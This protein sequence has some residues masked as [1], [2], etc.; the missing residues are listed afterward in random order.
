MATLGCG[1]AAR[2]SMAAIDI[3]LWDLTGKLTGESISALIGD[4]S[5]DRLQVYASHGLGDDLGN[6]EASARQ[7]MT[8]GFVAVNF[9]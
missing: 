4:R 7:L 3:A 2:Q 6:T 9:G 1:S 8:V 5:R